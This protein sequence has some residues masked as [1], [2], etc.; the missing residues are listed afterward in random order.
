MNNPKQHANSNQTHLSQH[1]KQCADTVLGVYLHKQSLESLFN[2]TQNKQHNLHHQNV[3]A[4]PA[5]VKAWVF[6]VLKHYHY[7][8]DLYNDLLKNLQTHTQL[9]NNQSNQTKAANKVNAIKLHTYAKTVLMIA[10][11]LLINQRYAPAIIVNEA[12]NTIIKHP[13]TCYAKGLVNKLLQFFVAF[14]LPNLKPFNVD[15]DE[16]FYQTYSYAPNWLKSRLN[17][18]QQ[19]A[20][21]MHPPLCLRVN[22]LKISRENYL[23]MLKNANIDA[24]IID[25]PLTPYAILLKQSDKANIENLPLFKEGFV[26][27][28]D[29]MAQIMPQI[30]P[31]KEGDYLLDACSAP[32]GKLCS[33]LEQTKL[34]VS[35][36]ELYASRAEK[37]KQNIAR[38]QLNSQLLSHDLV[39]GDVFEFKANTQFDAIILDAPCS[40]TGILRKQPDIAFLKSQEDIA[41]LAQLQHTMLKHLMQFLK[42]GGHLLYATCS[43]M[44]EENQ[45]QFSKQFLE[46][47]KHSHNVDFIQDWVIELNHEHDAFYYALLKKV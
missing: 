24:Q 46:N 6:Q 4:T 2:Q 42:P 25:N 12:I 35:S 41:Q 22:P 7:L 23:E 3:L 10:M 16:N 44:E 47:I 29:A 28:Q 21:Y 40:A 19:Q 27:V 34:H 26:A 17:S 13:K 38:L 43:M 1:I 8:N 39:I 20:L 33:Y 37:I 14:V 5:I 9:Q 30:L 32:G 36:L 18:A 45:Q 31:L 15:K 11:Y